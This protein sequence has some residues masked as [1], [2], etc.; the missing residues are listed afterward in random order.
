M[1]TFKCVPAKHHFVTC[2]S[3]SATVKHAASINHQQT[4]AY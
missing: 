1:P 4:A 2:N 3:S